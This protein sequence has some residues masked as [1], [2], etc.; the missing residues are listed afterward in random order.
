MRKGFTLIELLVVMV[1][2]SIILLVSIPFAKGAYEIAKA[3]KIGRNLRNILQSAETFI[4]M[5]KRIVENFSI[6]SLREKKYLEVN[7][8]ESELSNY[9]IVATEINKHIIVESIYTGEDVSTNLVIERFPFIDS[10]ENILYF[11][12]RIGKWWK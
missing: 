3:T 11:K 4:N 12:I 6:E 7:I 10:T 2:I 1:I 9:S 5:E 8:D